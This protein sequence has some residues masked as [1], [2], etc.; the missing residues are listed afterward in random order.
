MNEDKVGALVALPLTLSTAKKI[1]GVAMDDHDLISAANNYGLRTAMDK[2]EMDNEDLDTAEV[3]VVD[4]DAYE[5]TI[6][7]FEP[8]PEKEEVGSH[9]RGSGRLR[10]DDTILRAGARE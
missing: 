2:I 8:V 7:F 10:G 1:G 4:Q 3:I 5:A 6:Q 9:R